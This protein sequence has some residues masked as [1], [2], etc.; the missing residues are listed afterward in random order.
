MFNFRNYKHF[1]NLPLSF[2]EIA[3]KMFRESDVS[4][5]IISIGDASAIAIYSDL[6]REEFVDE[7]EDFKMKSYVDKRMKELENTKVKFVDLFSINHNEACKKM[8]DENLEKNIATKKEIE[9]R[10]EAAKLKVSLDKANKQITYLSGENKRLKNGASNNFETFISLNK[11]MENY[12]SEI[13]RLKKLTQLNNLKENL[14]DFDQWPSILSGIIRP[15]MIAKNHQETV[16]SHK[17]DI[18]PELISL[19]DAKVKVYNEKKKQDEE[20]RKKELKDREEHD[21]QIEKINGLIINALNNGAKELVCSTGYYLESVLNEVR[22][23]YKTYWSNSIQH[24]A[25]H[26]KLD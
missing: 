6:T 10:L 19:L 18:K 22:A 5:S 12:K 24:Q 7:L 25:I 13:A 14:T 4:F 2:K 23:K 8:E 16:K 1:F 26:I 20:K 11:E 17:I 15:D 21:R 3:Q 9:Y